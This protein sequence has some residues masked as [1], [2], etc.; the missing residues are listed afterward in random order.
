MRN[1][2][3]ESDNFDEYGGYTRPKEKPKTADNEFD[4]DETLDEWKVYR[5][6][7]QHWLQEL[8]DE[9]EADITELLELTDQEKDFFNKYDG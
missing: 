9:D 6:E 5:R 7:S 2:K 1:R 4:D 8:D 3:F